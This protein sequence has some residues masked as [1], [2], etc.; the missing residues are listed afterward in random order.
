MGI[1]YQNWKFPDC[2]HF[3]GTWDRQAVIETIAVVY[4]NTKRTQ[5][6]C[7]P[8]GHNNTKHFL[9]PIRSRHPLEFLEM[10]RW[11]SVPRGSFALTWKLSSRLFSRPD[12]LP[13]GLRGCNYVWMEAFCTLFWR[14]LRGGRVSEGIS[15][16]L[17][18]S[19]YSS[20]MSSNCGVRSSLWRHRRLSLFL[21][22]KYRLDLYN[23]NTVELVSSRS[24]HTKWGSLL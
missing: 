8:I 16:S 5:E 22:G 2:R 18:C 4:E 15:S 17:E 3:F 14:G 7:S 10:V 9:C 21:Y 19:I 23:N 1:L 6:M 24:F 11:E 20:L 12:W 13:L